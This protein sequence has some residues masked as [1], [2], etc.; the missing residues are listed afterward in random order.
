MATR[1][2]SVKEGLMYILIG[3]VVLF[4]AV[5]L[6]VRAGFAIRSNGEGGPGELTPENLPNRT[7]MKIGDPFPALP[8]K[9]ADAT[10]LHIAAITDGRPTVFGVVLPGCEPCENMLT[11]WRANGIVNGGDG[12]HIVLLAASH[13]DELDPGPLAKFGN[14]YPIYFVDMG[15]LGSQCGISSF[16]SVVGVKED[17]TISFVANAYVQELDTA[18]F[19]KY[20]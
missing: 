10:T 7:I 14:D 17:A 19:K 12:V 13:P 11:K 4:F 20:L 9:S 18:F 2:F 16:P 6:G 15:Q 1:A 8:I 5:F 3:G